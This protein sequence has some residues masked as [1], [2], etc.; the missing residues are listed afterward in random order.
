MAVVVDVIS[1]LE[2]LPITKEALEVRKVRD[3][4]VSGFIHFYPKAL[5][6]FTCMQCNN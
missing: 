6:H 2:T 1:Q 3:I 5:L 4:F